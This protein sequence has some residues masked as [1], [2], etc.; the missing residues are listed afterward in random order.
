MRRLLGILSLVA[1]LVVIGCSREEKSS[2]TD[3]SPDPGKSSNPDANL[4]VN[5]DGL[6]PAGPGE[7]TPASARI[8]W[9]GTKPNG[10]H[11][12]GFEKFSGTI[13]PAG[14]D[15]TA[16]KIS[17]EID[18]TSIHSDNGKLT[19]HLKT[20]DFFDVKLHPKATFVSTSIKEKKGDGVT[21]EITGD[22][23]LRGTKKS[24]SFPAKVTTTD[25]V[26]TLESLFTFDRTDFG[27]NYAPN[28]VHKVVT[29][30][31][32]AKVARK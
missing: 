29:V 30:R 26:L 2:N 16:S 3:K 11:D 32:G 7:L 1:V 21:H 31:V 25:D 18:T 19:A 5:L 12:G 24:I 6:Q 20:A 13:Q 9:V 17:I 28:K 22:L 8:T 27:I 15:F 4:S 10:S 23:T 14:G